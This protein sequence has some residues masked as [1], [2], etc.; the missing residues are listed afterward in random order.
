MRSP[1]KSSPVFFSRFRQNSS[2]RIHFVLNGPPQCQNGHADL[3]RSTANSLAQPY[4]GRKEA[5]LTRGDFRRPET[6][7]IIWMILFSHRYIHGNA[8]NQTN[9][10]YRHGAVFTPG[11]EGH[12]MP[13]DPRPR[14][15]VGRT[16]WRR[17]RGGPGTY[18]RCA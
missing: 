18:C 9:V 2:N 11:Q 3:P 4:T 5:R 14:S 7:V 10:W 6:Y 13:K 8:R 17:V 15:P 1:D 16:L 12:G